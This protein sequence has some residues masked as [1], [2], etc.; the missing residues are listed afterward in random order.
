MT[1]LHILVS[2]MHDG[3]LPFYQRN[4]SNAFGRVPYNVFERV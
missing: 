1:D 2:F 3:D 4:K